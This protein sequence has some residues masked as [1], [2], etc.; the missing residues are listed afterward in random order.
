MHALTRRQ[1]FGRVGMPA[2]GSRVVASGVRRTA[3]V[4]ALALPAATW[5]ITA[6]GVPSASACSDTN[7]SNHCYA[8]WY[9]LNPNTNHG[10]YG[11]VNAHCLYEPLDGPNFVTNEI[12]DV[13]SG[14]YWE[15]V[16][17]YSGAGTNISYGN[18]NWFWADKRPGDGYN[19]HDSSTTANTDTNYRAKVEFQGNDT[20]YIYGN[21]NYSHFGTSRS[22]SA[23]LIQGQAGTEYLDDLGILKIRDIGQVGD[24]RRKSSGD[25]WYSWGSNAAPGDHGP[26]HY[27]TS[28]Y[29]STSSTVSWSG[30]C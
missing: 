27:I 2:F 19:E 8:I 1:L 5:M 30:P 4:L 18:K 29:D 3:I 13:A 12:W 7:S 16:G 15:E 10:I 20:W 14:N 9:N 22:Q 25:T 28:H 17:L 23:T 11:V 21:G 6:V 26:G 24:L